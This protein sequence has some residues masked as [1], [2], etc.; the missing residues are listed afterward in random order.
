MLH[1]FSKNFKS[2]ATLIRINSLVMKKIYLIPNVIT[3]FGLACGLFAIFKTFLSD[4][5]GDLYLTMQAAAI[6]IILAAVADIADGAVARLVKAESEFGGQ[7]DS[8]SDAVTFGVAPP[9][10][11]LKSISGFAINPILIFLIVIASMIYSLCGVLRLVRFNIK[12]KE[13]QNNPELKKEEKKNFT[14]LPIPAAASAAIS[15][16]LL[17]ISPIFKEYFHISDDTR[18]IILICMLIVIGY[19]MVSRWKFPSVKT[20]H[21]RVPSFYLVF[22][23]GIVAVLVLYGIFEYFAIVF[24]ILSWIYLLVSWTLSIIRVIA[25]K[26]SKTLADFEPD[27]HDEEP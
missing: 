24:F 25:G 7:F 4:G 9:L 13:A 19:F 22:A 15:A 18:A 8:L 12:S 20:L 26:R 3:A 11:A 17:L 23:T 10:L 6:L 1:A 21:F 16:T 5:R 27:D 2:I 14:G